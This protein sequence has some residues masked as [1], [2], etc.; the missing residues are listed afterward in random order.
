VFVVAAATKCNGLHCNGDNR[1]GCC[2]HLG[3]GD[4][5]CDRDSDCVGDLVCGDDNCGKF[6][7]SEG[8]GDNDDNGWDTTDDCCEK[9]VFV[10]MRVCMVMYVSVCVCVHACM[11]IVVCMVM[12]VSVCVCVHACM[13]IGV[14]MFMYAY[15]CMHV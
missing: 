13:H 2:G 9:R 15:W 7:S 12:Y 5:D 4:G 14:Y 3:L 10:C 8:W 6:R 1:P 11:H